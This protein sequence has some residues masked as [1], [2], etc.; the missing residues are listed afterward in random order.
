MYRVERS[1]P[2]HL[3]LLPSFPHNIL[4]PGSEC[5]TSFSEVP[6][7]VAE[8]TK[9]KEKRRQVKEDRKRKE[10]PDEFYY[11]LVFKFPSGH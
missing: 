8:K 7:G 3:I 9:S 2:S 4:D 10:D 5:L 11:Y 1:T 6:R